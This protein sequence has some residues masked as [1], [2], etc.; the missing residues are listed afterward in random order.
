MHIHRGQLFY[1]PF[2]Y[3]AGVRSLVLAVLIVAVTGWLC[4]FTGTHNYGLVNVN[5]ASDTVFVI[6]LLEHVLHWFILTIILFCCGLVFSKS[7]IRFIDV[8]GTQGVSRFPLIILPLVRLIPS[9]RSFMFNST[10]MYM[11]FTLQVAVAVW[12]VSL[13]FHAYK[14]SCNVKAPR[15]TISFIASLFAA[16]ILACICLYFLT[17]KTKL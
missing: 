8:L 5:F 13:M 16:E 1:N 6:Y 15:L 2:V 4:F 17:H 12:A 10:I 9:F 14:I 11:L 7:T 3:I